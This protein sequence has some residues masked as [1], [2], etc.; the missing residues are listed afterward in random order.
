MEDKDVYRL[1]ITE[2]QYVI[3]GIRTEAARSEQAFRDTLQA[4]SDLKTAA[5]LVEVI[6]DMM[7]DF[8]DATQDLDRNKELL[9]KVRPGLHEQ[10]QKCI[11][12]LGH[13]DASPS[14]KLG[15]VTENVQG[16]ENELHAMNLSLQL[17]LSKEKTGAVQ[18][19]LDRLKADLAKWEGRLRDAKGRAGKDN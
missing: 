4:E 11:G 9:N 13:D 16:A 7:Q 3:E 14:V 8:K 1:S 5:S 10:L 19:D 17:E 15:K 2:Y 6:S 18:C 12:L